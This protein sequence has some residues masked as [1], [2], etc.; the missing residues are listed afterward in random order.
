METPCCQK[1][2]EFQKNTRHK[3]SVPLASAQ[4]FQEKSSKLTKKYRKNELSIDKTNDCVINSERGALVRGSIP[5]SGHSVHNTAGDMWRTPARR[6]I[7]RYLF[8][9]V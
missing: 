4:I 9:D 6:L 7:Q 8:K 1:K 2:F 5:P 3:I